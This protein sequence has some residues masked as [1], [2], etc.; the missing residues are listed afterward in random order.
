MPRNCIKEPIG[1][2][3]DK[4]YIQILLITIKTIAS[5]TTLINSS[6]FFDFISW[7]FNYTD[8]SENWPAALNL[9]QPHFYVWTKNQLFGVKCTRFGTQPKLQG[10]LQDCPQNTHLWNLGHISTLLGDGKRS[11]LFTYFPHNFAT[12][13]VIGRHISLRRGRK[14]TAKRIL[15]TFGNICPA[16]FYCFVYIRISLFKGVGNKSLKI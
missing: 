4:I 7:P 9:Y 12:F 3:A 14:I 10:Q 5:I 16:Q 11:L 15:S 1:Y 2:F 8:I 13:W 6:T